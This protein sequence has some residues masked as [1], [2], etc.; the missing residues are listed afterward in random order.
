M[1]KNIID[2]HV[3]TFP[4]KIAQ[5]AI[6]SLQEKSGTKA[7]YEGTFFSLQKS[8]LESG[9]TYSILQP[10]ATKPSQVISINNY[11]IKINQDS[12]K[13]K[14]ISFG[15][16]HPDFENYS[17][18]LLR[19]FN[20][21]IKGIKLHPVYQ[22]V[23]VDDEKYIKILEYA[24]EIGLITLIHAGW[25]VGFPGEPQAL[26]DKML[27]AL[28]SSGNFNVILAHMGG[29]KI[30]FEAQ[31]LFSKTNVYIDTAF[32]LGKITPNQNAI[33][34]S[35]WHDEDLFMLRSEEFL[36]LVKDYGSEKILF[37]TD[38]P[39]S[40]QIQSV[41]DINSLGL[42][43]SEKNNIFFENAKKLLAL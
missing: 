5:N 3:H 12:N 38:F 10:V 18:E 41:K 16:M 23:N 21:G 22:G 27:R 30:W 25:D 43:E 39:W 31:E 33:K 1:L 35:R 28:K 34:N 4:E 8:M 17:E 13:T 6:N 26:P 19:I 40:S 9:I 7:F 32:S 15:A 42:S 24:G 11:A 37:G 20:S 29:W 36:K 14:I 2:I